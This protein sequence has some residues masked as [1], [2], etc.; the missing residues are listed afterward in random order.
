MQAQIITSIYLR[1]IARG[2]D[3]IILG[4]EV[5]GIVAGVA[6]VLRDVVGAEAAY[7]LLQR[8]ADKAALP[9]VAQV[10]EAKPE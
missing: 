2:E 10:N 8:A 9:L 3:T 7:N 1:D 5:E 4:A 6:E